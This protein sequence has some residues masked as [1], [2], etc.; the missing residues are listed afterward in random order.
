MTD[1]WARINDCVKGGK[2]E[3]E[4]TASMVRARNDIYMIVNN[5]TAEKDGNNDNIKSSLKNGELTTATRVFA[6]NFIMSIAQ[7]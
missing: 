2:G 3:I 5:D 1:W 7:T 4:L 6:R